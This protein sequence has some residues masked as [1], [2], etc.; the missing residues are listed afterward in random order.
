MTAA[1]TALMHPAA[2]REASGVAQHSCT[3]GNS[4]RAVPKIST[5]SDA[6]LSQSRAGKIPAVSQREISV[7][8]STALNGDP[9]TD[10]ELARDTGV[11]PRTMRAWRRGENV[12][13]LHQFFKLCY[14]IPELRAQALHWL[15]SEQ[16]FDPNR[17]RELLELMRAASNVLERRQRALEERGP[18]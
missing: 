7:A 14:A 18:P 6:M 3:F 9:R 13:H 1:A 5:E 17:E 16:Q 11:T 4:L 10:K 12:P 15:E 8:V 2:K